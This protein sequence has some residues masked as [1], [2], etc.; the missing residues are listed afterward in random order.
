MRTAEEEVDKLTL[1]K[2]LIQSKHEALMEIHKQ[3]SLDLA[4]ILEEQMIVDVG[5]DYS[6]GIE[7]ADALADHDY[8]VTEDEQ[9][10]SCSYA[11]KNEEA[12]QSGIPMSMIIEDEPPLNSNG[13][14][15]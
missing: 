11:T 5:V 12:S 14:F 7:Y 2:T 10:P 3:Q 4:K 9:L 15:D 1:E 8:F 13:R 6:G